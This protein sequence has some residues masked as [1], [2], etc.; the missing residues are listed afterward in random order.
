MFVK[1]LN[2]YEVGGVF[3]LL[4]VV[5]VCG[6]AWHLALLLMILLFL[7]NHEWVL[8]RCVVDRWLHYSNCFVETYIFYVVE[9]LNQPLKIFFG[10]WRLRKWIVAWWAH[11]F[12]LFLLNSS[13]ICVSHSCGCLGMRDEHLFLWFK[14]IR[15]RVILGLF[16]LSDLGVSMFGS[17]SV[18]TE[19][20]SVVQ[21]LLYYGELFTV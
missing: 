4:M 14:C 1:P 2:C 9:P 12:V 8:L 11:S 21:G 19:V 3:Y 17:Y 6:G 10:L 18:M 16:L 7:P 15:W 5:C 20:L 13:V